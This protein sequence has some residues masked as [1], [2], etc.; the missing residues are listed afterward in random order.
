LGGVYGAPASR[1]DQR[2][3]LI[4]MGGEGHQD[5]VLDLAARQERL[6]PGRADRP[7]FEKFV[8]DELRACAR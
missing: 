8:D 1:P 6:G 2:K 5:Q 4:D 3:A 7:E